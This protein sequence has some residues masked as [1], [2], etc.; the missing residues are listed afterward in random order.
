MLPV[1]ASGKLPKMIIW[2]KLDEGGTGNSGVGI[3]KHPLYGPDL[4]PS[5]FHLF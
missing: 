1:F 3:M 4:A 2:D 5:D